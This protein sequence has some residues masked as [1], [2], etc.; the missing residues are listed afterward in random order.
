MQTA[1]LL[2]SQPTK[3]TSTKQSPMFVEQKKKHNK[4]CALLKG[5][6]SGNKKNSQS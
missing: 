2:S 4:I 5:R 1:A 3:K 6:K